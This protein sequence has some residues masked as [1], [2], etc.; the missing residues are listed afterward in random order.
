MNNPG[1]CGLL[2]GSRLA[3][4][5]LHGIERPTRRPVERDEEKIDHW[6]KDRWAKVK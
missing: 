3:R 1:T 2:R 6:I 4:L 5:A